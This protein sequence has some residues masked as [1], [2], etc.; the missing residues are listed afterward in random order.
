[1]TIHYVELNTTV[2][3]GSAFTADDI[4]VIRAGTREGLRFINFNGNGQYITIMNEKTTPSNKVI[5]N[6]RSGYGC[7]SISN[8]KYIDLRGNNDTTLEY[9]IKVINDIIPVV[10][11]SVWVYGESDHIKLSHLE[12]TCEGNTS[13]T[14]VGIQVQDGN[15]TTAWIHDTIEIHHNYIHNTRYCGMYLGSNRP[16]INNRPYTANFSVHDNLLEDLGS[17]GMTMK[18]VHST[19][20]ITHIYN[21]T[22]KRTGLVYNATA[23]EKRNG[24]VTHYYY[25]STYANVYGNW[26]EATKGAGLLIGNGAHQVYDNIIVGCGTENNPAFG[27]GIIVYEHQTSTI[28]DNIII[29]P[30]RLGISHNWGTGSCNLYRNLIGD[31]GIDYIKSDPVL[32]EGTGDDAN[33]KEA[34]VADFGFKIWSD[35]GDYSNDDFTIGDPC[36]GVVCENVCIGTDLWSQKCVNGL[37]VA[38][39]LLESNSLSCGY[40]PCEGIV[41]SNIC[42]GDDLW[43]QKCVNGLCAPDQLLE[44]NSLSC[45]SDPCEG[46]ICN[47]VCIG[48]DLWSQKCVNGLCVAD[49][50]IASN[51]TTCG[52]NPCEGVVCGN[53]CV[54]D[55][56][57]SQRCDPDTGDCI[58]NQL[59]Q[60]GS[61][62]CI[63]PEQI[64]SD[65]S[66]IQTYLILGGFGLMGLAMLILSKNNK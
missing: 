44:S 53:T 24:I 19:S 50:L 38:D 11:G 2:V 22:I 5:I 23:G 10:S 31:P 62:N 60:S 15:L 39:Q 43:S 30:V 40:D 51:S 64:P 61:I 8:C 36:E 46:V 42:V 12:I 54:G 59:I 52:Y 25:G 57:W 66:T 48:T 65:D 3:D 29:Q 56:L 28:Y 1:M 18:G 17:Y 33:W 9:G 26:I 41:C 45:E 6:G 34:D 58:P 4:I 63:I 32:I 35:D 13:T 49:Q 14:G 7:L 16:D 27:H 55:D 47:N 21:N 20:G 37:C